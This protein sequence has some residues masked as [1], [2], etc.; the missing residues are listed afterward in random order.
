MSNKLKKGVK[1]E[2]RFACAKRCMVS[3]GSLKGL[4]LAWLGNKDENTAIVVEYNNHDKH[5]EEPEFTSPRAHIL[6]L[7][8]DASHVQN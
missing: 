2:E 5:N 1:M 8:P 3:E 7:N 4:D 6:E